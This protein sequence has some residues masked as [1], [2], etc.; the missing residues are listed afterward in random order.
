M[1]T[2]DTGNGALRVRG[3][4]GLD[5]LGKDVLCAAVSTLVYTY[6]LYLEDTGNLLE[7]R[8][9][10]GAG[11]VVPRDPAR[12][13]EV[14]RALAGMLAALEKQFPEHLSVHRETEGDAV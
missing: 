8:T 10:P 14:H 2:V 6:A 5:S 7:C 11:T 12:A 4:A 3:H 13:E 1:V 9:E